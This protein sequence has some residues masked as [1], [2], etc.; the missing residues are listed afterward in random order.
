MLEPDLHPKPLDV[1]SQ[2]LK[3][4]FRLRSPA[5][6]YYSLRYGKYIS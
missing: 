3:F 4:E 1:W 5:W 2:S 6:G